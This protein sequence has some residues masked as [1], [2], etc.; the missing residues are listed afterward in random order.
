MLIRRQQMQLLRFGL[1]GFSVSGGINPQYTIIGSPV[2]PYYCGG[3]I[4]VTWEVTDFC[5]N[6]TLHKATFTITPPPAVVV[7]PVSDK[8]VMACTY[9]DQAAADAAF[10]AWKGG[11]S[12]S[13][14]INPQYTIIGSPVAPS[15]CGGSITVTWEVSDRCYNTTMYSATFTITAPSAVIPIKPNDYSK[16]ACFFAN[17]AEVDDA[18]AMFIGQF[19][20]SGGCNPSGSVD[21]LLS[22]PTLCTGGS[23]I[24]TYYWSDLCSSNQEVATFTITAPPAVIA[25]APQDYS[26][27]ACVLGSQ[28]AVNNAFTL[29]K[30]G[31]TVS[32]GCNPT[33]S[34]VGTPTAPLLCTGGTVTLTYNWSDLCDDGTKVATF[35]ITPAP[36]T[37][38]CGTD[39]TNSGL[40]YSV[41]SKCSLCSL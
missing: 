38:N 36:V 21:E 1:S 9:A 20:V 12:V 32:G 18:F 28:A 11:F 2:A 33:G 7:I 19:G 29:F 31:F 40:S 37:L 41:C 14:G 39:V 6:T 3:S 15:F 35:T 22:A 10:A 24:V 13:G 23:V 26:N 4:E 25:T 34:F 16:S 17:Q 8:T 5:Y 27:S 30:N